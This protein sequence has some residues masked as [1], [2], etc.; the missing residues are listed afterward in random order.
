SGDGRSLVALILERYK[1]NLACAKK[2]G[3]YQAN[4]AF[5]GSYTHTFQKYKLI[6]AGG[7]LVALILF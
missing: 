7:N 3:L 5:E 6:G 1:E 4:G 2:L